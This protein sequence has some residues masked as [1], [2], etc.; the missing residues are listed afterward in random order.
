MESFVPY[1]LEARGRGWG[2]ARIVTA[3][4]F[5]GRRGRV[6]GGARVGHRA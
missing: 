5:A 6:V 1:K 4:L 3:R 2:E